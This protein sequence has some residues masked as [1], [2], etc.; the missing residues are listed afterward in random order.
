LASAGKLAIAYVETFGEAGPGNGAYSFV[1]A[2]DA[3]YLQ[4]LA[5]E[6]GFVLDSGVLSMPPLEPP[7]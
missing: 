1:T 4:P 7:R 2:F 6:I 3:I 5:R